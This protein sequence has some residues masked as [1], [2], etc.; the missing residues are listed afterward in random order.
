[1]LDRIR[2]IVYL[3]YDSTKPVYQALVDYDSS[4]QVK[5]DELVS[6]FRFIYG[7]TSKIVFEV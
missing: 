7:K 6:T 3:T 4:V 1:M 5:Y 2:I